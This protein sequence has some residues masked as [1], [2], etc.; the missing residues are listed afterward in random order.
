M[1]VSPAFGEITKILGKL[2]ESGAEIRDV[3]LCGETSGYVDEL[4]AELAVSLPILRDASLGDNVS[5]AAADF[6]TDGQCLTTDLEV[7]VSIDEHSATDPLDG[8]VPA[9]DSPD[10]NQ[11]AQS[12]LAPSYKDPEA[13]KAVYE[14][15]DSFPE[16]TEAL[17]V[18]VTPETVR[19]HMVKYDIHDPH[20]SSPASPTQ[21]DQRDDRAD[22]YSPK[23]GTT[24]DDGA[25]GT[26][27][28][29][30]DTPDASHPEEAT[31]RSTTDDSDDEL[32]DLRVAELLAQGETDSEEKLVTDGLGLSGDLTV[33]RL[34]DVINRSKTVHEVQQQLEMNQ[35]SARR[36]LRE[37]DLLDLV[38][39][40]LASDQ[41]T[42]SNA[43]IVRRIESGSS[44]ADREGPNQ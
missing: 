13:L 42:V 26:T 1:V 21:R 41:I 28:S 11:L 40:R 3:R 9:D 38:S 37:F 16:M 4:T 44:E 5:I 35:S 31:A 36:L 17:G 8:V 24:A 29:T 30:T 20:D 22:E 25:S 33:G 12:E 18:D 10:R 43:E 32:S 7:S 6:D 27:G 23:S 39:H 15:Y 2:E 19:R 14:R 34:S